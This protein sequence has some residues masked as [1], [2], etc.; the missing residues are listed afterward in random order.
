V[1]AGLIYAIIIAMWA[2]VLVPMWIRR[3]EERRQSSSVD[4]FSTAMRTLR[5]P[6][7]PATAR[8]VWVPKREVAA[9]VYATGH[10]PVSTATV[11]RRS[12]AARRRRTSVGL[13]A[14]VA[15]V[16][17]LGVLGV[18]PG[19]LIGVPLLLLGAFVVHLRQEARREAAR[20]ARRRRQER[21]L[22]SR[23]DRADLVERAGQVRVH[24]ARRLTES[25]ES[26]DAAEPTVAPTA[27]VTETSGDQ[28]YDAVAEAVWEPV[29]VPL[30]TY[31]T[32][33]K[34]PRSVRTIDLTKP[35]AYSSGRL[36]EPGEVEAGPAAAADEAADAQFELPRRAVNG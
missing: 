7:A 1:G 18:I 8:E 19:W 11:T 26:F 12:L 24:A 6:A 20:R 13:I 9:E 15:V 5:R 27:S 16:G 31:V 2:V 17:L 14:V 33:P 32:A 21:D 35:G 30:P 34:A 22:A 25:L 10:Q 3:Y 29:P 28:L 23:R 4:R 36:E